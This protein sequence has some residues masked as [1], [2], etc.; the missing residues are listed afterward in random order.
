MRRSQ[1]GVDGNFRHGRDLDAFFSSTRRRSH[2]SRFRSDA[3]L[4]CEKIR[5]TGWTGRWSFEGM[6][7]DTTATNHNALGLLQT[8]TFNFDSDP[9]LQNLKS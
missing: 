4:E 2:A 7:M 6:N 3:T 8:P 1:I 9:C 5:T